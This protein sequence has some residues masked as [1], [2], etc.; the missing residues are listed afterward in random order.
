MVDLRHS[1]EHP[2]VTGNLKTK[3]LIVF[4]QYGYQLHRS[5]LWPGPAEAFFKKLLKHQLHMTIVGPRPPLKSMPKK[6]VHYLDRHEIVHFKKL[7]SPRAYPLEFRAIGLR[8]K[9]WS[10]IRAE[11]CLVIGADGTWPE[12]FPGWDAPGVLPLETLIR[13]MEEFSWIPGQNFIFYGCNNRILRSGIK[14]LEHGVAN[15]F[16]LTPE[17]GGEAW[18]SYKRTFLQKGGRFF[19]VERIESLEKEE[20]KLTISCKTSLGTQILE[21]DILVLDRQN[22]YS[23]NSP[24]EWK[25]GLFYLQRRLSPLENGD[26]EHEAERLDW[27]EL[28][29]RISHF[30]EK[31][32]HAKI[33]GELERLKNIR[34]ENFKYKNQPGAKKL[35]YEGKILNTSSLFR[36]KTDIGTPKKKFL[37][38]PVASLECFEGIPCR[39]CA[40]HC[41]E[42]AIHIPT[43]TH[44][45]KLLEELCIGCG[46][47]VK[48]CPSQSAFMLY[49]NEQAQTADLYL[50][51][52]FDPELSIVKLA[53]RKGELLGSGKIKEWISLDDTQKKI[54][55]IEMSNVYLWDARSMIRK[56][57]SSVSQWIKPEKSVVREWI[58]LNEKK[59][60]SPLNIPASLVLWELGIKRFEDSLLCRD[61]SCQRCEIQVNDKKVKACQTWINPGD[62]VNANSPL[63]THCSP[64]NYAI[65]P[66]KQISVETLS[67]ELEVF[68]SREL[69]R[70][71]TQLGYGR[72]LGRWCM[73]SAEYQ[74]PG[75][76]EYRRP[77]FLGFHRSPWRRLQIED[78]LAVATNPG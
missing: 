68:S 7:E 47:C 28:Y 5:Q 9:I 53:N 20:N 10:R 58:F 38:S 14:L 76:R 43:L 37:K 48:A 27:A 65:C 24:E 70:E 36:I 41:P 49:E 44:A 73:Q 55:K 15:C 19:S 45:P 77:T 33:E 34:K 25:Q 74:K 72:C 29:W 21:T 32:E 6:W 40:D 63:A 30:F 31:E 2:S 59:R 22:K 61:G 13:M 67:R 51:A 62:Q 3:L 16:I 64:A 75:N 52:N 78:L 11:A 42:N 17:A 18:D 66:C 39:Q 4:T 50:K 23:L 54:A 1:F 26:E 60:L 69:I 56:P 35:E 8:S 57:T 46:Q 12:L 71:T